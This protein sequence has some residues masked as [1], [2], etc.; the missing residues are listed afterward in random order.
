MNLALL[1]RDTDNLNAAVSALSSTSESKATATVKGYSLDVS[2]HSAWQDV[3]SKISQDFES[4]DLLMLNA[5][6]APK[7]APEGTS[8]WSDM[9]YFHK[10]LDTNL[11]GVVNGIN[12]FLPQIR[13][14]TGPSAVVI[15]G[16]KQGI[17]NPPG[18]PAYNASKAAVKSLA[19]H[20]CHD[21][22]TESNKMYAPHVSVHLLVPGWTFTGLSGHPGPAASEEVVQGKKP[23]G[24]WLPEQTAKYGVE[25]MRKGLFYLIV[26]DNDVDESLDQ[27]RMEWAVGDVVEG[28]A[29]LSRWSEMWKG[30]AAA[31]IE[32]EAKKRRD[33]G[34]L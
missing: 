22:R 33:G 2:D 10:T 18:N 29:A 13:K 30:D 27:A 16:S 34:V 17:T 25:G 19:E 21:L 32:E 3:S 20:L 1:D 31:W 23:K 4:V 12:T 7:P 9:S 14:S 6:H 15:T 5:G 28:R 11:M 24:A 8:P 26:P